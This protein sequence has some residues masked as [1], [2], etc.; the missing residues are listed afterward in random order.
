MDIKPIKTD[1]G[2]RAVF[3]EIENLLVATPNT[4]E[5]E[6]LDWMITLIEACEAKH[7]P[8]GLPDPV[9]AIC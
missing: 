7:F 6:K 2:Y 1:A 9:T 3:K 4:L 5:C 8:L